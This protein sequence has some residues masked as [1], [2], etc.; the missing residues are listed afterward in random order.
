[1]AQKTVQTIG[2]VGF[3]DAQTLDIVIP[4][5]VFSASGFQVFLLAQTPEPF[6]TSKTLK[7]TPTHTFLTC[8]Q[9]D[10]IVAVGGS[11]LSE[12]LVNDT[13]L[14]FLR[15]QSRGVQWVGGV[16]AGALLLAFAGLLDGYKAT[17][18][19]ASLDLLKMFEA[20]DVDTTGA[21]YV[22]DRNRT[23]CAGVTAAL[24]WSYKMV[25]L[26][27][28]DKTAKLKA[29]SDEYSPHPPFLQCGS[30]HTAPAEVL[31]EWKE[32]N[33]AKLEERRKVILAKLKQS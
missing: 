4:F 17:T 12:Q 7:L 23:T 10:V 1:M 20:I 28:D 22:I 27:K 3:N 25:S 2:I 26:F 9:V 14:D 16:C 29:L 6:I 21:R 13:L 31:E 30:P 5:E 19:W 18:H 33:K 15:R 24:D 32:K 8:P 11:G